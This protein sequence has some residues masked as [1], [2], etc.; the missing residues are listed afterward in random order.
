MHSPSGYRVQPSFS[1][2]VTTLPISHYSHLVTSNILACL[3]KADIGILIDGSSSVKKD[4]FS[5]LLDF[6]KNLVSSFSVSSSRA[7]I[8]VATAS[9]GPQISFDFQGFQDVPSLNTAI[10]RIAYHGGP[11]LLGEKLLSCY[12]KNCIPVEFNLNIFFAILLQ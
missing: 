7:H 12:Q 8:A 6:T 9:R 11:F 10:S 5:K 1:S 2:F 3:A 4:N